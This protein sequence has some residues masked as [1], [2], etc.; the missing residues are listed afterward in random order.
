MRLRIFL[1]VLLLILLLPGCSGPGIITGSGNVVTDSRSVSGFSRV[2]LSGAGDMALTQ[3]DSESLTVEAE[4]NLLPYIKTEVANGTLTISQDAGP[5]RAIRT[6]KPIKYYLT[7]KD[8][9]ALTLSGSGGI[10][11]TR[12]NLTTLELSL[13]GSGNVQLA[14]LALTTLTA[15]LSGSGN[16]DLSGQANDQ[17]VTIS[18]SGEYRA[19]NLDTNQAQVQVSGSGTATVWAR[20]TL[21]VTISGSGSVGYYGSPDVTRAITGSGKVNSL[22]DKK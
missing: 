19:G 21:E 8:L 7:V 5:G 6:T 4:D 14:G 3:G 15:G 22:G 17:Q 16:A 1:T 10:S 9:S 12:L 11:A 18:G 2:I 13:S 20:N